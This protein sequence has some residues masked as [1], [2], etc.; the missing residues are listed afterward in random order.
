[1]AE[2]LAYRTDVERTKPVSYVSYIASSTVNKIFYRRPSDD[3]ERFPRPTFS[4]GGT[5]TEGAVLAGT[6]ANM[7]KYFGFLKDSPQVF[8]ISKGPDDDADGVPLITAPYDH[9][10]S[11]TFN[12][13]GP[14]VACSLSLVFP[15]QVGKTYSE[16][17]VVSTNTPT[18][19]LGTNGSVVLNGAGTD[20][21]SVTCTVSKTISAEYE[22]L[23]TKCNSDNMYQF[24]IRNPNQVKDCTMPITLLGVIN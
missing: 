14:V 1:M 23:G 24:L 9:T 20:G 4:G 12:R 11:I 19:S 15:V 22:I 18:L 7:A 3:S 8:T 16:F 5:F 2:E 6:S 13:Y 17:L 21:V 10:G